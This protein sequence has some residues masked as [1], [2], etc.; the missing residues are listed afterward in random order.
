M[1]MPELRFEKELIRKL[2]FILTFRFHLF[3]VH[4][5]MRIDFCIYLIFHF[6]QN[7]AVPHVAKQKN[8]TAWPRL[9]SKQP[10]PRLPSLTEGVGGG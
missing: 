2:C 9:R 8:T 1:R 10:P 6:Y 5:C 7:Y 3:T 4:E